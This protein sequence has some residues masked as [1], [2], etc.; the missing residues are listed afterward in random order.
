MSKGGNSD[1]KK[2]PGFVRTAF[3]E[4]KHDLKSTQWLRGLGWFVGAVWF[5]GL[6][7]CMVSFALVQS[8]GPPDKACQPDGSFRLKPDSYSV[9]SSSGFFQITLG[10]GHLTFAQAK[11]VDIVWD[12]VRFTK[13]IVRSIR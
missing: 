11:V 2:S 7:G 13:D 3:Q 8:F 1:S 10:G 5:A 6:L 4:L 12:I 9:W